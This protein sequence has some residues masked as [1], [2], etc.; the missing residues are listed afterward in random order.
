MIFSDSQQTL[1][2]IMQI[3][4]TYSKEEKVYNRIANTVPRVIEFGSQNVT[5]LSIELSIDKIIIW[6]GFAEGVLAEKSLG[7]WTFS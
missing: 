6:I 5:N 2:G 3:E 4:K 7:C 1:R